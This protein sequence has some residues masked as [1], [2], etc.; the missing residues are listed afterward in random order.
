MLPSRLGALAVIVTFALLTGSCEEGTPPPQPLRLNLYGKVTSET[1]APVGGAR[2]RIA[3][4]PRECTAAGIAARFET[5]TAP[6]GIYQIELLV[7]TSTGGCFTI[8]FDPPTQSL[9]ADSVIRTDLSSRFRQRPPYD[10]VAVNM[11]L[12]AS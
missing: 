6:S 12:R 10:N 3:H 9:R 1:G 5:V 11:Q 8:V 4:A 2:V 7:G